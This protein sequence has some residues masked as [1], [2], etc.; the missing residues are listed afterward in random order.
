M[1]APIYRPVRGKPTFSSKRSQVRKRKREADNEDST[2]DEIIDLKS[3]PPPVSAPGPPQPA[4]HHAINRTDPYHVAGLSREDALPP[5]P[6]PHAAT[7][8][9]K[10]LPSIE[11]EF[12]NLNPP[13]YVPKVA[14]EDQSQSL[15]RRHIDNLTTLL[16]TCTL[17]G[18]WER[19]S[20]AWGLLLRTEVA[21]RGMDVRQQG[22]WGIGAELLMR[23]KAAS[24]QQTK[25]SVSST[26]PEDED[27]I[28]ESDTVNQPFSDEGFRLAREYYE[29]LIL[30]YPYT[31]YTRHTINAQVFYPALLNV[32]VYEV[33]HRSKR[34]RKLTAEQDQSLVSSSQAS[35]DGSHSSDRRHVHEARRQELEEALPIARRMDEL[36]VSPP[37]DSSVALLH[38]RGMVG[39]WVA[40]LHASIANAAETEEESSDYGVDGDFD[41]AEAQ[42]CRDRSDAERRKALVWLRKAKAAGSRLPNTVDTLLDADDRGGL[43]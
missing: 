26:V 23:R 21:G 6:F 7:K 9:I 43:E 38:L 31:Q 25:P 42:R 35:D 22:R 32:W 10:Q 18:D 34:R 1:F 40:D 15:K 24:D 2:D 17:R 16:H 4:Y 13:L 41:S 19:A 12:D 37:Y 3:S 28:Q 39:L 14:A 11:E 33:Q 5:A 36:M 30:Q 20:R 29:R 27:F 8:A